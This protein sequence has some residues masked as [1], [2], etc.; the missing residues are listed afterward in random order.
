MVTF[1]SMLCH[2]SHAEPSFLFVWDISIQI[3]FRSKH[4]GK[5]TQM[6]SPKIT[7]KLNLVMRSVR[8]NVTRSQIPW[9][10][11]AQWNLV[12]LNCPI[13]E[14]S[15]TKLRNLQIQWIL[16]ENKVEQVN[17]RCSDMCHF[18]GIWAGLCMDMFVSCCS[19][20]TVA[21]LGIVGLK[22]ETIIY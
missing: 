14:L 9:F 8:V 12:N 1:Q 2:F 20:N 13:T 4:N 11:R 21:S 15:F 22:W 5:V 7:F 17:A 3:F 6:S 16:C 19:V 10:R 18:A